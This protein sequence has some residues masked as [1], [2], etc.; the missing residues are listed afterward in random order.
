M[1]NI[2]VIIARLKEGKGNYSLPLWSDRL[3][4]MSF[5]AALVM[6][7]SFPFSFALFN[8]GI[9]LLM[10]SVVLRRILRRDFTIF[11]VCV[12]AT[13]ALFFI[14]SLISVFKS[15]YLGM[16]LQGVHK[17]FRYLL[18][19]LV[20]REVITD[21]KSWRYVM[22]ALMAGALIASL[23]GLLQY[24]IGW[25]PLRGHTPHVGFNNLIRITSSFSN[26]NAF[27]IYLCVL[28]PLVFSIARYGGKDW[29]MSW[30]LVL[31]MMG[32]VGLTYSRTALLGLGAAVFLFMVLKRDLKLLIALGL[33]C[34]ACFL[35]LPSDIW[36]W[37]QGLHSLKGFLVDESRSHYHTTAWNMIRSSPW[38]GVGLNTFDLNYNVFKAVGDPTTRWSAHQAYLQIAAETGVVG[39]ISF[40]MVLMGMLCLWY[41]A[42]RRLDD[43]LLKA[44][45]L[46]F[47][48][49][50]LAFLVAGFFESNLWQPKQTYFFWF[51]CGLMCNVANLAMK[52][53]AGKSYD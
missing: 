36:G 28:L 25:D 16:S 34:V 51:F 2:P 45:L 24:L 53:H 13:V 1:I 7:V 35:L 26:S 50:I 23:D 38:F 17:L 15:Q 4:K 6:A 5:Y 32:C 33:V 18:L 14:V 19:F 48:G 8:I 44:N 41:R 11:D 43:R 10:V 39:L 9:V 52:K 31:L 42:Y 40:L 20:S 46:G 49:G 22:L 47:L 21:K 3:S 37:L 30:G 12:D 29:R 27:V